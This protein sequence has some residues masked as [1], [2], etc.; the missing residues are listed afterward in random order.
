MKIISTI[1]GETRDVEVLMVRDGEWAHSVLPIGAYQ[2]KP[3]LRI[4]PECL[5]YY[6]QPDGMYK[7]QR[8]TE[9][10]NKAGSYRLIGWV[11]KVSDAAISQHVG[12]R[13][14]QRKIN[15]EH[16]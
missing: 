13:T 14:I 12:V 1:N 6:R 11:D 9:I 10:I 7:L 15:N 5:Y 8:A 3:G 4:W 16:Y 2:K